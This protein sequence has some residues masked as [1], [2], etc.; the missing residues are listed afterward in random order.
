MSVMV[1]MRIQGDPATLEKFAS[2]NAEVMLKVAAEGRAA[3]AIRHTFAGGEG[4]VLVIDEWPDEASFQGFFQN[5][6]DIP[7]IMQEGG[8]QGA[9]EIAFY[10]KLDTPD[11]F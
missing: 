9:P 11:N 8:A 3:G 7:R 10:R 1:I 5:Q 4:E 2:A 6:A